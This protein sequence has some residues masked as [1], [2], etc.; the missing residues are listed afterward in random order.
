VN[1][2]WLC[3]HGFAVTVRV[4]S[5]ADGSIW[6]SHQA[7]F[8]M[9]AFEESKIAMASPQEYFV[10]WCRSYGIEPVREERVGYV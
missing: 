10:E 8:F 6:V 3:G 4:R 2:V 5:G 9:Y 7:L 1:Q